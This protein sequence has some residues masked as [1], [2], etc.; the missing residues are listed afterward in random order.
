MFNSAL[1][2]TNVDGIKTP[3]GSDVDHYSVFPVAVLSHV[4]ESQEQSA[5]YTILKHDITIIYH[6]KY[7]KTNREA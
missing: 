5:D 1:D 6:D 7:F 4:L 3:Y 2:G